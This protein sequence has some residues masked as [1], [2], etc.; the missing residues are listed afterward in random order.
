LICADLYITDTDRKVRELI[1][2]QEARTGFMRKKFTIVTEQTMFIGSGGSSTTINLTPNMLEGIKELR[3]SSNSGKGVFT[4]SEAE[5]TAFGGR[6]INGRLVHSGNVIVTLMHRGNMSLIVSRARRKVTDNGTKVSH[7][8][9]F[10]WF[11]SDGTEDIAVWGADWFEKVCGGTCRERIRDIK[12]NSI[13]MDKK[14]DFMRVIGRRRG[15][16]KERI[17]VI[18]FGNCLNKGSRSLVSQRGPALSSDGKQWITGRR[19][20]ACAS[21]GPFTGQGGSG[22]PA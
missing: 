13:E 4:A 10:K 16:L 18:L 3:V 22:Q 6:K 8:V 15:L 20:P 5:S 2:T 12:V 21:R 1:N 14:R 7:G 19:F 9:N 11:S 17:V